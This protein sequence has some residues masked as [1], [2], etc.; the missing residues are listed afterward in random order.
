MKPE[1][2]PIRIEMA[3]SEIEGGA[4]VAWAD[5]DRLVGIVAHSEPTGAFE[6]YLLPNLLTQELVPAAAAPAL[7]DTA[8]RLLA[9][10][11]STHRRLYRENRSV[12]KDPQWI[13]IRCAVIEGRQL[14]LMGCGQA[15]A[16]VIR[17]QRA[18]PLEADDEGLDYGVPQPGDGPISALGRESSMRL[19]VITLDLE[20]MDQVVLL[21][22]ES[23]PAPDLRAVASAFHQT[24]DLKRGCDGLVNLLGVQGSSGAAVA[25]RLVPVTSVTGTAVGSVEGGEVLE[26]LVAEVE[27]MSIA[28]NQGA[29]DEE[30]LAAGDGRDESEAVAEETAVVRAEETK[31][32]SR[33]TPSYSRQGSKH[34]PVF[35]WIVFFVLIS[36][37]GVATLYK[38][39]WKE[40]RERIQGMWKSG[41]TAERGD[42]S[43]LTPAEAQQPPEPGST[44]AVSEQE[45]AAAQPY[46]S[47]DEDAAWQ[48]ED[49][50]SLQ[51]FPDPLVPDESQ[52]ETALM[53]GPPPGAGVVQVVPR[54]RAREPYAWVESHEQRLIAPCEFV[55]RAGWSR[56]FYEDEEIPLW[57]HQ[58]FIEEGGTT[59]VR[60]ESPPGENKAFLHV[61]SFHLEE[62]GFI[63]ADGDSILLDGD[64]LGETP[65]EGEVEPG[66]HS[67]RV[68]AADGR[69]AIEVFLVSE[70]QTR[71]FV[72][73]LGLQEL[74][75]FRHT[76]PGR[77]VLAGPILL[78]V[79][80]MAPEGEV[81]RDPRLHIIP[82]GRS[83]MDVPL[84]PV[85]V[86]RGLYVGAVDPENV[87]VEEVVKYYFSCLSQGGTPA[88]SEIFEVTPVHEL[89]SLQQP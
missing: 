30:D 33:W 89:S 35:L 41:G 10:L 79:E 15:W 53:P 23:P 45:E 22:S 65:W 47:H 70:G 40:V 16:Y 25:F 81:V 9:A 52:S 74:P 78:S 71:Y 20:P 34:I 12:M 39:G 55:L 38:P 17:G 32:D 60:V 51:T 76:S 84:A 86:S 7:P 1:D 6:K 59:C 24:Q 27:S 50:Q 88:V 82:G 56:V 11:E 75:R 58:V 66:W 5:P 31:A 14:H 80:I 62:Q 21:T 85:E 72:P 54:A 43:E 4:A 61:E 83:Q 26:E 57:S 29:G 87:R 73:R 3:T 46:A 49:P 64:Q 8:R 44:Q 69:Q 18:H 63:P 48:E 13:Q 2:V 19:K 77:A 28:L 36:L 67:L 37:V 68:K 42:A